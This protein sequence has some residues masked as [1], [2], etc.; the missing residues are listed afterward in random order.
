MKPFLTLAIVLVVAAIAGAGF[1]FLHPH[2][3]GE[4]ETIEEPTCTEDGLKERTCFCGEKETETIA[5]KGHTFSEWIVDEEATCMETG[6]KHRDCTVCDEK[7]TEV[8][9]VDPTAHNFSTEWTCDDEKHWHICQNDGCTS[10]PDETAH[11]FGE[12]VIDVADSCVQAGVRHHVCAVCNKSVS[13]NYADLSAHNYSTTWTNNDTHHWHVCLNTGCA[14]IPDKTVHT[15]GE[16]IIDKAATCMQPGTRHHICT[17]C[18]K[19]VSETY[20]DPDAHNYASAWTTDGTNHWHKCQNSGCTS[21]KDKTSHTFGAWVV[22]KAATCMTTGTRHHVCIACNKSVS[23]SYTDATAH[24]YASA[25]TTDGT[26]HWHECQNNGCTS[27]SGK[28][29]HTFGEWIVDTAATCQKSGTRHKECTCG[30]TTASESYTD[31]TAHNYSTSWTSDDTNH[32]HKCLNSGCTAV[33]NNALHNMVDGWCIV[34]N[35]GPYTHDGKYIY[36]GE[37]P[38]TIKATSVTITTTQDSR[39]YY[40]G[41]DGF[42][43]AKVTAAPWESGYKFSS[44][45]TVTTGT[46]YYFKVEPIRWRIL[47]KDGDTAFILCDSIIVNRAFDNSDN[48]YANSD[49]RAWLNEEFYCTAFSELQQ[50]LINTVLVDNSSYSILDSHPPYVCENTTDKVF[51]LSRRE[52]ASYG[53]DAVQKFDEARY[54]PVCDYARATGAWM[55]NTYLS[56]YDGNGYWWLRSPSDYGSGNYAYGV[57]YYGEADSDITVG[58]MRIGVVPALQIRL[59]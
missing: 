34:C 59:N 49:I 40:L 36:F 56:F 21:V 2:F 8:I 9:P 31:A 45:M 58:N 13:E 47:S 54:M 39:G 55:N 46:V 15:F 50:S 16:W 30:Y 3:F 38:Q 18:N 44:G 52:V 7:E 25:W 29:A 41:S 48:N 53:F 19:S 22:D 51:L 28:T 23:E 35:Y 32:W 42:Y 43:Y 1:Y 26:N 10:I 11:T 14:S 57:S 6:T 37:Y 4:W 20:S 24:N 17:V 33:S 27:V 12:W 5:A